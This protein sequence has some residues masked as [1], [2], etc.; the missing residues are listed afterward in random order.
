MRTIK[1]IF[2]LL[3]IAFVVPLASRAAQGGG[4]TVRAILVIASTEKGPSDPKLAPYV[5]ELRGALRYES[6]RYGGESSATVP[7]GGKT[8]LTVGGR[9][10]ELQSEAGG[11]VFVRAPDG[12]AA[13]SPGGKPAVI[14][15]GGGSKNEAY[16]ILAMAK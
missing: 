10:V 2:T 8:S 16:F 4:T 9:R 1:F 5:G 15:V 14:N 13:V 3:L 11:S 6:Y 7:A 12:G